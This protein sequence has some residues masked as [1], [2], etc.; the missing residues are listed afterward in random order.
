MRSIFAQSTSQFTIALLCAAIAFSLAYIIATNSMNKKLTDLGEKQA[1]FTTLSEVDSFAREK[2]FYDV[3]EEILT[4]ELCSAY[5][6]AYDGRAI[7]LTPDE[8]EGSVYETDTSYTVLK[9]ADGSALVI[10]TQEQYEAVAVTPDSPAEET[11]APADTTT[12]E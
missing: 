7:F 4:I 6:R 2:S 9:L 8:F 5:A 12:A 10:L 3:D 1:L 11:T